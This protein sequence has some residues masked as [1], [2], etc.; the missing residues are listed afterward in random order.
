MLPPGNISLL[1][2]NY[3][4]YVIE[5]R[6]KSKRFI[7]FDPRLLISRA[8]S[9]LKRF[10]TSSQFTTFQKASMYSGLRFW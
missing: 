4:L 5:T 9:Y 8:A 6:R 2:A 10:A 7:L 3:L 1:K